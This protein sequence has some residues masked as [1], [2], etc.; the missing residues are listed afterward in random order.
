MKKHATALVGW[1]FKRQPSDFLPVRHHKL[2]LLIMRACLAILVFRTMPGGLTTLETQPH[3]NGLAEIIN[4]TFL[5]QQDV[6]SLLKL[7][8]LVALGFYVVG[9][10]MR[11]ALVVIATIHIAV[12]SLRNSQGAIGHSY[13]ILSLILFGQMLAYW[14]PAVLPKIWATWG[15]SDLTEHQWAAYIAQQIIAGCYVVAGMSKLINS[16]GRWIWDSPNIAVQLIKTH[17]QRFYNHLTST[18]M[19][20]RGLQ[21]AEWV[22]T[23]PNLSR[24]MLGL[25]LIHI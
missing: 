18:E 13:Q 12:F 3:P 20:A 2:E 22:V 9:Q 23:H 1:F 4:L 10:G 25:S 11:G 19:S 5:H 6:F 14:F 16:D 24:L 7:V 15:R 17:D 8:L 21:V